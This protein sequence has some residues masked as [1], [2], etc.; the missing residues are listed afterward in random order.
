[1]SE[2]GLDPIDVHG[3]VLDDSNGT[4][5]GR[6]V[7][8]WPGGRRQII[9]SPDP[10]VFEHIARVAAD[11]EITA[12]RRPTA[13]PARDNCYCEDGLTCLPCAADI[14]APGR[15]RRPTVEDTFPC[16]RCQ[17]PAARL[18]LVA[19]GDERVAVQMCPTCAGG[20]VP[21]I[22]DPGFGPQEARR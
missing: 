19:I 20:V 18:L 14:T 1:M 13:R 11:I 4:R 21:S 12:R 10:A 15:W 16:P 8:T 17:Q 6:L 22:D 9:T 5:V 3:E 2:L 7:L